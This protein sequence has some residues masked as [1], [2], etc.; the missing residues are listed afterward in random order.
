[1]KSTT[2]FWIIALLSL[3]LVLSGCGDKDEGPEPVPAEDA[4]DA[5]DEETDEPELPDEGVQDIED[6]DITEEEL[7]D[8]EEEDEETTDDETSEE[9]GEETADEDTEDTE[10]DGEELTAQNFRVISLKDLK[11][12]PEEMTIN[13]ELKNARWFSKEE[14]NEEIVPEYIKDQALQAFDIISDQ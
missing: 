3:M 2:V 7:P 11:A 8:D 9:D 14:L 4:E 10:E 6:G 5:E 1:M 13:N 12:Y